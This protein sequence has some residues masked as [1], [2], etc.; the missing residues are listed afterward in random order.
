MI[1]AA[2][3]KALRTTNIGKVIDKRFC[4]KCGEREYSSSLVSECKKLAQ[5]KVLELVTF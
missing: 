2:K 1:M 4:K 3:E 5:K